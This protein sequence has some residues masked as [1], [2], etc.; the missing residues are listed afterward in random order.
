MSRCDDKV[1]T[2]R[3]LT[4]A[5]IGVPRGMLAGD[6]SEN[7]HFLDAVGEVV[8]KP[9]RGEQGK[10]ITVGVTEP[11]GLDRAIHLAM[12]HRPRVLIEER[13]HGDDLRVVVIDGDVVAAAVRRPASVTGTG[14][15]TIAELI[16][17]QSRRRSAA[18]GGESTIPLDTT[19]LACVEEAGYQISDVL[20][21]GEVLA[22][23]RT[24]NLHTGGTIHD[25]TAQLHPTLASVAVAAAEAI[26]IPVTGVDLIVDDPAQERYV[27]IE[28]NERPGLANHEPHP[29]AERFMDLLFP[30]TSALPRFADPDD[31]GGT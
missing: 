6:E 8:V 30:A 1:V 19:T 13:V 25:V 2:R 21:A 5:G 10:G 12:E 15:H 27:V 16:D 9:A 29:T 4:D 18:T 26:G 22:V 24:A 28:V 20:P 3:V 14:A 7:E 11:A 31:L 23:Q 17:R